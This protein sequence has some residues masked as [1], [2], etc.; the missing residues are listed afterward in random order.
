MIKSMGA[1]PD[2]PAGLHARAMSEGE[3]AAWRADEIAGYAADLSNSGTLTPEQAWRVSADSYDEMLPGG[4]ATPGNDWSVI[5]AHGVGVATIWL[6]HDKDRD[7]GFVYSVEVRPEQRGKGYGRAA[8]LAGEAMSIRAGYTH[9]GLNV[10]GHNTVAI[11]L[12]ESLGYALLEQSRF[13]DVA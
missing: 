11:G 12:Y 5:E 4:L 1:E 3:Y 13:I 2:L 9:L 6:G 7:I 10:F 8:M